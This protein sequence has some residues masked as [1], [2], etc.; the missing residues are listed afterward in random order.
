MGNVTSLDSLKGQQGTTGPQGKDGPQGPVGPRGPIGSPGPAG[1]PGKDGASGLAGAPGKD[2]AP[3]PAFG[4]LSSADQSIFATKAVSENVAA[5]NNIIKAANTDL[6]SSTLWCADG[7]FCKAP[8]GK[9]LHFNMTAPGVQQ[10]ILYA[11]SADDKPRF[12]VESNDNVFQIATF[13]DIGEWNKF[14]P[15]KIE[16]NTGWVVTENADPASVSAIGFQTGASKAYLFKNGVNRTDDGG[17][18]TL[19]LRNDDGN[20]RLASLGG[21]VT[22][23]NNNL[24]IGNQWKIYQDPDNNLAIENSVTR[25][26]YAVSRKPGTVADGAQLWVDWAQK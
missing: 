26:K 10:N 16:R 9:P 12:S 23:P 13:N 20:L 25:V 8:A 24:V 18:K 19:T 4:T 3:G 22:I 2:G 14:R 1:A 15:L 5:I 7:T 21:D 17:P 11:R 6:K